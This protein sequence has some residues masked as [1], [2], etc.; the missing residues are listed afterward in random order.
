[1]CCLSAQFKCTHTYTSQDLLWIRETVNHSKALSQLSPATVFNVRLNSLE[2]KNTRRSKRGGKV[3]SVRPNKSKLLVNSACRKN[4][5]YINT[6][7]E[8]NLKSSGKWINFGLLNVRSIKN[9]SVVLH[10]FILDNKLDFLAV[11]E[12]WLSENQDGSD[13]INSLTPN[14]HCFYSNPRD[15]RG[16]GTGVVIKSNI[17]LKQIKEK[18]FTNFEHQEF[19]LKVVI[20]VVRLCVIY[21]P[22]PNSKNNFSFSQ[23]YSEF[24]DYVASLSCLPESLL[25]LGDFNI[26]CDDSSNA[27][28]KQFLDLLQAH[29]LQQTVSFA[30]HTGGHCIDLVITRQNDNIFDVTSPGYPCVSDHHA[31]FSRLFAPKPSPKPSKTVNCRKLKDID[32]DSLSEDL[33][34]VTCPMDDL[35]NLL[36]TYNNDLTTALDKHAPVSQKKIIIRSNTQWYNSQ[37]RHLKVIKRRLETKWKKCKTKQNWDQYCSHCEILTKALNECK[38]QFFSTKV[39][40]SENDK[41]KLFSVAKTLLGNFKKSF[42]PD[43]GSDNNIANSFN[44]YFINKIVTI[45]EDIT[46]SATVSAVTEIKEIVSYVK[47]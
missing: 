17:K 30:T 24:S 21:R 8:A 33:S 4:L 16:G 35:D 13:I 3:N 2:K 5:I 23:F 38:T 31:V 11:T 29:G 39:I 37:I 44:D 43:L 14:G 42:L 41:K 15:N 46:K 40:E 47:S 45:P 34:S 6:Q 32:H 19:V 9:K 25:L 10:D 22:P 20:N 27:Q 1:M 12:T 36:H 7:E 18:C 26:H 28:V